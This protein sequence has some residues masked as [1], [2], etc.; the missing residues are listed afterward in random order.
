M[1]KLMSLA[2]LVVTLLIPIPATAGEPG[3]MLASQ[4]CDVFFLIEDL[5]TT[6]NPLGQAGRWKM[7][8]LSDGKEMVYAFDGVDLFPP[9]SEDPT[10]FSGTTFVAWRFEGTGI[11]GTNRTAYTAQII[12]DA[13]NGTGFFEG[14][15]FRGTYYKSGGISGYFSGNFGTGVV[16]PYDTVNMVLCKAGFGG[17]PHRILR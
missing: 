6:F 9:A 10:K 17:K 5:G 8:R 2:G 3:D 16:D 7:Q 13:A 1:W 4:G 11:K 12:D 14:E 15:T